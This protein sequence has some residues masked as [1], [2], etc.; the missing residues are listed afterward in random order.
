MIYL[1]TRYQV[2][3]IFSMG[4]LISLVLTEVILA[5]DHLKR[6]F[7]FLPGILVIALTSLFVVVNMDDYIEAYRGRIYNIR[8]ANEYLE[9]HLPENDDLVIGAWAPT[10]TW[11][12]KAR[13]FPVWYGFLNYEDPI[14]QYG[15]RVVISE[16]DEIDSEKAYAKQGIDL[17]SESDSV[18]IFQIGSWDVGI[19]WMKPTH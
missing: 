7:K 18:R 3:L 2:S 5:S 4:L 19:F 14:R 15:P 9:K 16:I 13:S 1:P 12:S 10:M 17:T 6:R 8:N 11:T